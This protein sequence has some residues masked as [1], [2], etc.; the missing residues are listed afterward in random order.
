M[1][2][3]AFIPAFKDNYIWLLHDDDR[4]AVVVDPGDA[5]AVNL[6]LKAEGFTLRAILVTHHH[7]DHQGGV[8]GLLADHDVP[9][10]A[11]ADESITGCT[12]P[13]RGGESFDLLG[14]T[15]Q[16]LAVPG[17][18][19]GHLAYL[20]QGA[21]FCGDTLFGAGCGRVF[22]GT[23]AQMLASLQSLAQLDNETLVYCAH[24]YTEANLRF[25][26]EVEPKNR[27]ISRR[28]AVAAFQRLRGKP[29]LPSTIGEEKQT[30][31]FLR[32]HLPA[33]A[34]AARRQQPDCPDDALS[35]FTAIRH[36]K[37]NY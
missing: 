4:N 6:R 7:R 19:V 25:A 29:T 26:L 11:P 9:V 3:I 34:E 32:C 24:E 12:V 27:A 16:V 35:V 17:H 30:N 15:V 1:L 21:L 2:E 23:Q 10:Y 36:W 31:P 20:V 14:E 22:E 5:N 28:A 13:L 18:T 33:V 8:V 37:N